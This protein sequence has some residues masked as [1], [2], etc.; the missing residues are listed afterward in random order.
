MKYS[1]WTML[2]LLIATFSMNAQSDMTQWK[3][4]SGEDSSERLPYFKRLKIVEKDLQALRGGTLIVRLRSS[5]KKIN[6]LRDKGRK[7]EAD[8]ILASNNSFNTAF[9]NQMKLHYNFS[10]IQFAYGKGIQDF[11]NQKNDNIFLNQALEIDSNIKLKEGPIYI[12]AAQDDNDY[13]L[14]DSDMRRIP[15]P[16]PHG[17]NLD[18]GLKTLLSGDRSNEIIA[19]N[20][21]YLLDVEYFNAKLNKLYQKAILKKDK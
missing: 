16:A 17:I 11:L 1:F 3:A 21:A 14:F 7:E 4:K 5:D 18:G 19:G 6:Y 20:K 15:E 2:L 9:L 8:Q 12:L 13:Y 10:D